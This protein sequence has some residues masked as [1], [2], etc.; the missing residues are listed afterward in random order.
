MDYII[1]RMFKDNKLHYEGKCP[2]FLF[3]GIAPFEPVDVNDVYDYMEIEY[4]GK[5]ITYNKETSD[6]VWKF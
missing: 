1:Y 6:Q 2:S 5:T 3:F 4:K